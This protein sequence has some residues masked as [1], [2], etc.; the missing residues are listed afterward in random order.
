MCDICALVGG[1][2]SR[3]NN[4]N[5]GKDCEGCDSKTTC[6]VCGA[7]VC[8]QRLGGSCVKAEVVDGTGLCYQCEAEAKKI[9][10]IKALQEDYY[11][12]HGYFEV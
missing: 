6:R 5:R 12:K 10:A 11:G 7:Q 2:S 4:I 3:V 8:Y 1:S 9:M